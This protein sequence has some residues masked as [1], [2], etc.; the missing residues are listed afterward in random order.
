MSNMWRISKRPWDLGFPIAE[1]A[2]DGTAVITKTP[3]SG[4]IVNEWTVKEHLLY[5]INDPTAT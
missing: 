4:G 3:D 1:V 5:E 2:E